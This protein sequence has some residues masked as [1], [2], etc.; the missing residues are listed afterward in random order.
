MKTSKEIIE[1]IKWRVLK[2]KCIAMEAKGDFGNI[3]QGEINALAAL[4][5]FIKEGEE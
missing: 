3:V 2:L 5:E 1:E 4:L